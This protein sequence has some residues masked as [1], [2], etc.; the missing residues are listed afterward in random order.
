MK[1]VA[2]DAMVVLTDVGGGPRPPLA[3]QRLWIYKVGDGSIIGIDGHVAFRDSVVEVA[4]EGRH[5]AEL[6]GVGQVEIRDPAGIV[7][8]S[9]PVDATRKGYEKD[10]D[11]IFSLKDP[12]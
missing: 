12:E 2:R 7:L 5:L 4:W 8:E 9:L 1:L 10:G 6:A 3:G 11:T